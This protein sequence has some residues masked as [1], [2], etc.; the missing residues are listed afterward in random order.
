MRLWHQTLIPSL[1]IH[2]LLGQHRECAAL[3][4]NGWMKKHSTIN[5]IFNYNP[6]KLVLY[7]YLIIDEMFKRGYKPDT[8]WLN[9]H[10]RGQNSP[11]FSFEDLNIESIIGIIYAEHNDLYLHECLDNLKAK[12]IIIHVPVAQ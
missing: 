8:L 2:Q 9:P 3:R 11:P 5:Y 4:G 10:Y 12:G 1:P 6:Y 7:H